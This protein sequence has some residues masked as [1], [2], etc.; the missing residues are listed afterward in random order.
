MIC[1]LGEAYGYHVFA[2]LW[3]LSQYEDLFALFFDVTCKLRP[4]ILTRLLLWATNQTLIN[5]FGYVGEWVYKL[6]KTTFCL[7]DF[8][9]ELHNWGCQQRYMGAL[10]SGVGP[11][12]SGGQ[13]EQANAFA[14]RMRTRELA[15]IPR[16]QHSG[17]ALGDRNVLIVSKLPKALAHDAKLVRALPAA[18]CLQLILC[19]VCRRRTV[20][21]QATKNLAK[22][23]AEIAL[24]A[25]QV[26]FWNE[27]TKPQ[28]DD[29][30]QQFRENIGR[31]LKVHRSRRF[32]AGLLCRIVTFDVFLWQGGASA[33]FRV[34]TA[35]EAERTKQVAEKLGLVV[36]L[37]TT[38]PSALLADSDALNDAEKAFLARLSTNSNVRVAEESARGLYQSAES[39]AFAAQLLSFRAET[40]TLSGAMLRLQFVRAKLV[41]VLTRIMDLDQT[42]LSLKTVA[43]ESTGECRRA[44]AH[45][46]FTKSRIMCF[47][48]RSR[49]RANLRAKMG[50]TAADRDANVEVFNEGVRVHTA[51]S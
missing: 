6:R 45:T 25:S 7:D 41:A 42:L 29:V 50:T 18:A 15:E 20:R 21:A 9:A 5:A 35:V 32:C 2:I 22:H 14:S 27:M 38:P 51:A 3:L 19:D 49:T 46:M 48:G 28:K 8:H 36:P 17:E 11:N 40:G 34:L 33:E 30:I 47:A 39:A 37:E 10:T 13:S 31:S 4:F 1:S 43:M 24:L 44:R 12:R 26:P 23:E 16:L